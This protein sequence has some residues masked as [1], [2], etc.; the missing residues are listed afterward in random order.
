MTYNDC[1][2]QGGAD[3]PD[4]DHSKLPKKGFYTP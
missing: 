3:V 1:G 4:A 2:G